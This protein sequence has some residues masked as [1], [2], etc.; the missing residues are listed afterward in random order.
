MLPFF[1]ESSDEAQLDAWGRRRCSTRLHGIHCVRNDHFNAPLRRCATP[2]E[3]AGVATRW[4][5]PAQ[6]FNLLRNVL[7]RSQQVP[8]LRREST[9]TSGLAKTLYEEPRHEREHED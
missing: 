5:H 6:A 8:K 9:A 3:A 2:D 7:D 4:T 1:E